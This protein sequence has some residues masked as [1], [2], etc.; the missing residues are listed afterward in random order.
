MLLKKAPEE[1]PGAIDR[2]LDEKHEKEIEDLL[3]KIYE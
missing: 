3:L 2:L 1:V